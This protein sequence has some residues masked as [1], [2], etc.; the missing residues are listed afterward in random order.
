MTFLTSSNKIV[1]ELFVYSCRPHVNK[2]K[3][4]DVAQNGNRKSGRGLKF[5]TS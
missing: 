1:C 3:N 5:E 4:T 2:K